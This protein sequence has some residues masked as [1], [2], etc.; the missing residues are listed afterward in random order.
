[1]ALLPPG[2][3][4]SVAGIC[5][6]T[7]PDDSAHDRPLGTGFFLHRVTGEPTAEGGTPARGLLVTNKHVAWAA[8]H[9][10]VHFNPRGLPPT[11]I[12]I[13]SAFEDGRPTWVGH[14]ND[15][16]DIAV[17]GVVHGRL[18]QFGEENGLGRLADRLAALTDAQAFRI[19][20]LES[21][22]ASEGDHVLVLGFP[23]G[24]MSLPRAFPIARSGIIARI[25]DAMAGANQEFF[26]DAQIFPGNSGGP[27]FLPP[28]S[29]AVAGTSLIEAGGLIGVVKAVH[30]HQNQLFALDGEEPEVRAVIM[31]NAGL[32][33][34][35]SVDSLIETIEAYEAE[36]PQAGS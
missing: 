29:H 11:R 18:N 3:L 24:I 10:A 13:P 9:L 7:E 20:D 1:M 16:V 22:G 2:A 26:I 30:Q 4:D 35:E 8:D 31:E 32:G 28:Q 19:A 36:Y 14:P 34:V 6:A 33:V 25:R 21:M 5:A 12:V 27:V 15:D 23:L 17:T